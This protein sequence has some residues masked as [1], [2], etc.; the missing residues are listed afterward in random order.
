MQVPEVT[1]ENE[2]PRGHVP[3]RFFE[4]LEG[5]LEAL[6]AK[7][8]EVR[9][10]VDALCADYLS[11]QRL[12]SELE[13]IEG[14]DARFAKRLREWPWEE[15]F[16]AMLDA[17]R[18]RLSAQNKVETPVVWGWSETQQ[19]WSSG[20]E[21]DGFRQKASLA[22]GLIEA[23]VVEAGEVSY[24]IIFNHDVEENHRAIARAA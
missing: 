21:G 6:D 2:T 13:K 19:R 9:A 22:S 20:A 3:R 4:K 15:S 11:A 7:N 1:Q 23:L 24:P 16:S 5:W 14:S 18:E 17:W 12:H 10:R 8:A